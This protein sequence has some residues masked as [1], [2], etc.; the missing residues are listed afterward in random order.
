MRSLTLYDPPPHHLL[1][2]DPLD[3][4]GPVHVRSMFRS[5]ADPRRL[6]V[7]SVHDAESEDEELAIAAHTLAVVREFRRVPMVASALALTLFTARPGHAAAMMAALA[8]FAERAVSLYQPS[9]VLLARS[10][11]HPPV[12]VLVTGVHEAAALLAASS[13]A[14][15]FD[16][17]LPELALML[18]AEPEH[19][20]YWRAPSE[21][22]AAS[23]VSPH[24]V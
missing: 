22:D 15:S 20:A 7:Y 17:L 19:F 10:L 14:F 2:P 8:Y 21:R 11:E 18:A 24:A 16:R 3:P 4:D 6:A 1:D 5:L 12:A 13:A 9:Y 23:L